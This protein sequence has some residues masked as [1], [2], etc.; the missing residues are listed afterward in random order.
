MP[1]AFDTVTA[2]GKTL[3]GQT[4]SGDW[5]REYA[6]VCG[7][8]QNAMVVSVKE[9]ENFIDRCDK[10]Q[11]RIHELDGSSGAERKVYS[12]RLKMCRE[13]FTFILEFKNKRR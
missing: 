8:T 1:L 5:K 12:K 9:L 11:D 3:S 4:T 2:Q 13:L 6:D 7:K 10:L